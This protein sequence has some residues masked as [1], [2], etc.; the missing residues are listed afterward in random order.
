MLSGEEDLELKLELYID[1]RCR[2][3]SCLQKVSLESRR[4]DVE[5][6]KR[7][8]EQPSPFPY[9][10]ALCNTPLYKSTTKFN[11]GCG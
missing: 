5:G 11:S 3:A 10:C 4:F 8:Y 9:T 6:G 2:S 1:P 7:V